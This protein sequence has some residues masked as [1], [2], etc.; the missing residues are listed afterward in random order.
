[1]QPGI[2]ENGCTRGG[3]G[4]PPW[5]AAPPPLVHGHGYARTRP[6]PPRVGGTLAYAR[7]HASRVA[8]MVGGFVDNSDYPRVLEHP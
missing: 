1:M 3:Y 4:S 7:V 6:P 2:L 8:A 5:G